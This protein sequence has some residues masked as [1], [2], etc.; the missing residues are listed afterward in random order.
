M[1]PRSIRLE[2]TDG[3]DFFTSDYTYLPS[4]S[5]FYYWF[6]KNGIVIANALALLNFFFRLLVVLRLAWMAFGRWTGLDWPE[7]CFLPI[8]HV[9]VG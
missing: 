5:L 1:D 6:G 9:Y 2:S 3:I 4:L 8:E 7:L